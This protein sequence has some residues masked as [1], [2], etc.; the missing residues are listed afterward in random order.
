MSQENVEFLRN[1][2]AGPESADKEAL[3]AAGRDREPRRRP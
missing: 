3:I 1:L 2:F